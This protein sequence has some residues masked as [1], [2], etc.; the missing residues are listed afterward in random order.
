[1]IIGATDILHF[2]QAEML[3]VGSMIDLTAF[4]FQDMPRFRSHVATAM[5]LGS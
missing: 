2:A 4:R 1:M 3:M 5:G